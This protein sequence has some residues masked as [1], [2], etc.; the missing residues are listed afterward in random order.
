MRVLCCWLLREVSELRL[1]LCFKRECW[2]TCFVFE[3]NKEEGKQNRNQQN[4]CLMFK[5]VVL[6]VC[7]SDGWSFALS[8]CVCL[9]LKTKTKQKNN[10]FFIL[11]LSLNP[12]VI[13]FCVLSFLS[14]CPPDMHLRLWLSLSLV[15]RIECCRVCL[16]GQICKKADWCLNLYPC[17]IKYILSLSLSLFSALALPCLCL[18]LSLSLHPSV[19]L[20]FVFPRPPTPTLFSPSLSL[21][22]SFPIRQR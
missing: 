18:C 15:W 22:L 1:M 19:F 14:V 4:F 17:V 2:I 6:F 5:C 9:A 7:R 10:S 13:K 16:Q 3:T 11:S 21:S 8:V 12:C 20:S